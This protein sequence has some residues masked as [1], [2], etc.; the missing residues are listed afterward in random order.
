MATALALSIATG[1]APAPAA[2]AS[3]LLLGPA[4]TQSQ[5]DEQLAVGAQAERRGDLIEADRRYRLAWS[6]PS[7]RRD[8]A[9]ALWRLHN[10][11]DFHTPAPEAD[12]QQAL[13]E[14]GPGFARYETERFVIVTDADRSI[15]LDKSALLERAR[16]QFF[17]VMRALDTPAIPPATKLLCI[18]FSDESAY[19]AFARDLDGVAAPWVAGYYASLTN[20]IVLYDDRSSTLV[21]AALDS[22]DQRVS[23]QAQG[24]QVAGALESERERILGAVDDIA[25]EK[26]IHEAIHLLAFNSGVQSR[27]HEHPFWLTEGL[28]TS[29]ESASPWRAFGPAHASPRRDSELA[30]L[31]GDALVDL[32]E[33]IRLTR[34]DDIPAERV[35][36]L[37]ATSYALFAYLHRH[38]RR[39][40]GLYLSDLATEPPGVIAPERQAALFEARF[41]D[42]ETLQRRLARWVDDR[43][44]AG[45]LADVPTPRVVPAER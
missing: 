28:A 34:A 27:L 30:K 21:E 35:D 24:A 43:Q 9:D 2:G 31:G 36:A 25:T 6:A 5:A 39:N 15:A 1:P 3:A 14:V 12:V 29:F 4:V 40:L 37:Y 41:G 10:R 22:L 38:E 13:D 16:H 44:P 23:A 45:L 8:A 42:V 17:R 19:R 11:R 26:T 32:R 33:L 7:R 20:R 18:L